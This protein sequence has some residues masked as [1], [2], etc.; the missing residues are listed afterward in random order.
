MG[1]LTEDPAFRAMTFVVI[2]IETTTPT[3]YPA[4][5]IEVAV[6][7]LRCPDGA[8][9]E[10]GR[11]ASLIRTPAF[12]PVTPAHAPPWPASWAIPHRGDRP[13]FE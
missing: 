5:P 12:A 8:W 6:L 3:G 1:A 7:A 9:Q 13:P 4:Q 10:T 11:N 2:D